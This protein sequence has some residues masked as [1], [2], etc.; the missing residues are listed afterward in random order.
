VTYGEEKYL[1]SEF[2]T[3]VNPTIIFE[4]LSPSTE[5][6]DRGIKFKMYRSIP[7]L[8]NYVLISSMEYLAEVYTRSGDTWVLTTAQGRDSHI[9]ISSINY[10]L[11]LSDVY[12]QFEIV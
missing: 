4:V 12:A 2:D 11:Q 6:Y 7:S 8:Q 5:N 9:H 3:L 10:D 1:D